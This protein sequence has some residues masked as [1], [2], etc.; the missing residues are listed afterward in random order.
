MPDTVHGLLRRQIRQATHDG[1]L[2]LDRLYSLVSS[3]Y[4]DAD[5]DR[6]REMR[7]SQLVSEELQELHE[8]LK[9]ESER[10]LTQARNE[11]DLAIEAS[12]AG[13]W[14]W[15]I[16]TNKFMVS[17]RFRS[18]IGIE[19]NAEFEGFF[20]GTGFHSLI[21]PDDL[22]LVKTALRGITLGEPFEIEFRIV[23]RSGE[24]RW[25]QGIGRGFASGPDHLRQAAGT[26]VDVTE[27][28]IARENLGFAI[29][30]MNEGFALFDPDDCLQ[31]W[32][33]RYIEA[34]PHLK[35]V[36]RRGISF[37]EI[38]QFAAQ[39]AKL[40]NRDFNP[41][42]WVMWRLKQHLN[43]GEAFE[44]TLLD[45]RVLRTIERRTSNGGT[46]LTVQDI[47]G[48]RERQR[49]LE[50]AKNQAVASD[51]AKSDFLAVMSHEIRTPLNGVTGMLQIL[52][53]SPLSGQQA[54]WVATA[55]QSADLL[56]S[57]VNNILDFSKLET[58]AFEPD[59]EDFDLDALLEGVVS[60]M[61][62]RALQR[63]NQIERSIPA[64]SLR[65]LRADTF[66]LRQILVNLIGNAIKFTEHGR[67][68]IRADA[69]P[70]AQGRVAL[71][72]SVTDT[73]IGITEEIQARL[74]RRFS[75]G[76]ASTTRKYGGTG[77][78]LA[79]CKSLVEKMGGNIQVNSASGQGASFSFSILCDPALSVEGETSHH[80]ATAELPTLN[81]NLNILVAEDNAT[82]QMVTRLLL[83]G[84]GHH[85]TIVNNGIEAV[86]A[87]RS[88]RFDLVLMDVEMPEMD[89]PTAARQIRAL[90]NEKA[91][92]PIIALTANAFTDQR[93]AYLDSGMN[94]YV[95]KPI[96]PHK[97]SASIAR[98]CGDGAEALGPLVGSQDGPADDALTQDHAAELSLLLEQLNSLEASIEP[99]AR[100]P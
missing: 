69:R 77:L 35:S 18:I 32:N 82:N 68:D 70:A 1:M 5:A 93:Q 19:T 3:A 75:Q 53:Q 94:D 63:G 87:V 30:A 52:S 2:D 48:E 45:G 83:E 34:F 7:A 22:N 44:Q 95:S 11:L 24:T 43:P 37:E 36:L 67:I 58:G 51:K 27:R 33:Q 86:Q 60:M 28:R 71:H 6:E 55:Q 65:W 13:L 50:E 25:L 74:F 73:G 90:G 98:Q 54:E 78:G 16:A 41:T 26:I 76:D 92:I 72:C 14:R 79:I 85:C 64:D 15:D 96:D 47:T 42:A 39:A 21:H 12:G 20:G 59:P 57:V 23:L 80:H 4:H 38:T 10:R 9:G 66:R 61:T 62:P 100:R 97:L 99:G 8:K 49:Q 81:R 89:G 88:G 91:D 46:V 17:D 84:G 29:D 40:G 56:L 31:L